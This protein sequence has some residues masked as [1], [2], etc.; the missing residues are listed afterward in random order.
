MKNITTLV[1]LC[2]ALAIFAQKPIQDKI[3]SRL[4]DLHEVGDNDKNFEGF[5]KIKKE[6]GDAKIVMLGEQSHSDATTFE[7]KIKLVK[8]LHENPSQY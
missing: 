5:E 8:Y 7:T 4:I 3:N 6:I 2:Y 1:F